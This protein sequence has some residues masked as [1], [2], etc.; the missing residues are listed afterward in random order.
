MTGEAQTVLEITLTELKTDVKDI[1][2]ALL[3]DYEKKG[4]KTEVEELKERVKDLEELKKNASKIFWKVLAW[5]VSSSAGVA[6][7]IKILSTIVK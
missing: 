7:I 4:L 2:T 6:L 5:S 1:K 3:G